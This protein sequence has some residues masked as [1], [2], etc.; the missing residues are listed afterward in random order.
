[1]K[2]QETRNEVWKK[3]LNVN[4]DLPEL[5]GSE[6]QIAWA[7]DIR[8]KYL[9]D[10]ISR[11]PITNGVE[12]GIFEL[13]AEKTLTTCEVYASTDKLFETLKKINGIKDLDNTS[14]KYWIEN[15]E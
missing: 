12:M 14:A 8:S 6:K 10:V 5:E 1:M 7:N 9:Q 13:I 4:V 2:Y 15:R 3:N 11:C